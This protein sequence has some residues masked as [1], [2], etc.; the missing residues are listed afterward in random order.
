MKK[1]KCLKCGQIFEIPKGNCPICF[2]DILGE[3][4][5]TEDEDKRVELLTVFI[6]ELCTYDYERGLHNAKCVNQLHG[7]NVIL[8]FD[9]EEVED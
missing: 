7:E 3:L 4:S 1:I 6:N 8:G 9:F 5:D 2:S